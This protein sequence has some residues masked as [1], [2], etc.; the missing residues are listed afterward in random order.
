M[1]VQL[2]QLHN[3]VAQVFIIWSQTSAEYSSKLNTMYLVGKLWLDGETVVSGKWRGAQQWPYE[4]F[5]G[6]ARRLLKLGTLS[7]SFPIFVQ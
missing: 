4:G 5:I 1:C 2:E 7:A 6:A 3:C